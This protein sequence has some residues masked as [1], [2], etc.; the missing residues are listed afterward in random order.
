MTMWAEVNDSLDDLHLPYFVYG[1]LRPGWGNSALWQDVAV[2]V[3]DGECRVHG[4]GLAIEG[5][6][7]AVEAPGHFVVGALI[8]PSADECD[9]IALR[10]QLDALE[11]YPRH[12]DRRKVTVDTLDVEF[13]EPI[14]AFI[15]TPTQWSPTPQFEPTGDWNVACERTRLARRGGWG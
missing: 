7:Y 12:Y 1:T 13:P 4:Y 8:V 15:Y 3:G 2:A 11:G 9:R 5:L 14:E 10:R 6:P